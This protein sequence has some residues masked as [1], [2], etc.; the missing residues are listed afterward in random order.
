MWHG[1]INAFV[2]TYLLLLCIHAVSRAASLQCALRHSNQHKNG[3]DIGLLILL[4]VYGVQILLNQPTVAVRLKV[5]CEM[6]VG[7]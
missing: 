3:H 5:E 7:N 6:H 2:P 4:G 1:T